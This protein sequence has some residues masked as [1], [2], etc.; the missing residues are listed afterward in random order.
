MRHVNKNIILLTGFLLLTGQA[1]PQAMAENNYLIGKA[2]FDCGQYDSSLVYLDKALNVNLKNTDALFLRGLALYHKSQ[3]NMAIQDLEQVEKNSKGKASIWL[4]RCYANLGDVDNCIKALEVHLTSNYRLPES[5]LLLDP[6]LAIIENDQKYLSFMKSGTWYT[7]LDQT[8][9]EAGYLIK[10]KQYPE[11]IN[12][13]S[14]G[15]KKGYRKAPLYAKRAE[16]YLEVANYRLALDDLNQAIELD[17][18]NPDIL[19]QRANV[20]YITGKYKPSMDDYNSVVKMVPGDLKFY[21]GW[22]MSLNKAGFY[23]DAVLNMNIFLSYY[24]RNDSAWYQLGMIHYDNGNYFDA[25]N[26]FNNSLKINQK[27]ARYFAFRGAT[28]LKTRTYN[29]AWKDLAMALDLDPNDSQTYVNKGLAALN[30]G[31][32][33]DACFCF[34]M[35]KKL[36]NK[37]G[38]NYAEKYC[39]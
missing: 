37:E 3:Y 6:D 24:P 13:L 36:G 4:A 23:D 15:L 8:I 38:F 25:I 10:S 19:A 34:D 5:T 33:D 32:N 17:R 2:K 28:Y 16:V 39:K 35:A 20:L 30:T 26:C 12:I 1:F 9:A 22:A 21:V 14:E 31:K 7:G 27:D 18:R 29:Y 11:A